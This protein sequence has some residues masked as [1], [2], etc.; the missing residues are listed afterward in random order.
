MAKPR[1]VIWKVTEITL[2]VVGFKSLLFF[3]EAFPE[4]FHANNFIDTLRYFQ[5]FIKGG[6][7][8]ER[9]HCLHRTLPYS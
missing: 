2:M 4:I 5:M 1:E 7:Y 8:R 3:P 9:L 6:L